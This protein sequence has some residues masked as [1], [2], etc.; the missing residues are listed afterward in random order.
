VVVIVSVTEVVLAPAEID[1][2]LNA[3]L[4]SAGNPEHANVT[5][6]LNALLPIG[7][8]ENE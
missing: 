7:I 2:G 8:A 6:E 4:V 3:Q 1:I 5:F